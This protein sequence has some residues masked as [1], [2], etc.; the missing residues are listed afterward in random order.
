M[1]SSCLLGLVVAPR[2]REAPP[3]DE[4]DPT[5]APPPPGQRVSGRIMDY[6]VQ[7]TTL[8]GAVV[9]TDGIDPRLTSTSATDGTF[10]FEI[11]PVGS[12]IFFSAS[13]ATYR[14]TRNLVAV[15]DTAVT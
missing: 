3:P 12:Q 5:G 1:R 8:V 9:V 13:R 2:V 11:V 7:T 6:F 4:P 10:D 14:A 15:A